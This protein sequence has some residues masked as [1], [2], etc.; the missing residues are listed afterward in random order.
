VQIVD[1]PNIKKSIKKKEEVKA[2]GGGIFSMFCGC[3]QT[4]NKKSKEKEEKGKD[5]ARQYI[6]D[7]D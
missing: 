2:E 5:R 4:N 7:H 3:F 1:N 6:V